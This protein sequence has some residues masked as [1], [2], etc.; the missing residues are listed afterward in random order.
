[1]QEPILLLPLDRLEALI[2]RRTLHVPQYQREIEVQV[3]HI[4]EFQV[5]A[6][7]LQ[8]DHICNCFAVL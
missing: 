4:F 2:V 6:L 8:L 7:V 5:H 3:Q 1:M